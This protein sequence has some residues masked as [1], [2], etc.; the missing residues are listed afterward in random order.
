MR[1]FTVPAEVYAMR[2]P[3]GEFAEAREHNYVVRLTGAFPQP[4]IQRAADGWYYC[5]CPAG[6]RFNWDTPVKPETVGWAV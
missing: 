4:S 5:G 3:C 6:H 2:L 1:S